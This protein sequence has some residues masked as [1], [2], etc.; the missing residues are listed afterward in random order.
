M[1]HSG[2]VTRIQGST[3]YLSAKSPVGGCCGGDK[4]EGCCGGK[5]VTIR[6]HIPKG[7]SLRVGDNVEISEPQ[8][9]SFRSFLMVFVFP[10]VL[11]ALGFSLLPQF[12]PTLRGSW[13][14]ATG[15]GAFLLGL[16]VNLLLPKHSD[17]PQVSK[18][19]TNFS[20]FKPLKD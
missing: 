3:A 15:T 9:T 12:V 1:I 14:I 5:S 20:D 7:L 17:L 4:G 16:A 18:V 6:T 10:A 11:F 2:T 19:L 8:K 13:Q